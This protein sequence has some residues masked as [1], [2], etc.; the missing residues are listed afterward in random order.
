MLQHSDDLSRPIP[1][2]GLHDGCGTSTKT[3]CPGTD[4]IGSVQ[5]ATTPRF[6]NLFTAHVRSRLVGTLTHALRH[7]PEKYGIQLDEHGWANLAILLTNLHMLDVHWAW[8]TERDLVWLLQ[9][10]ADERFECRDGQIRALYG[11]SVKGVRAAVRRLPPP[12][13][14]HATDASIL[15]NVLTDGLE[16]M[17]RCYVHLTSDPAYASCVGASKNQDWVLLAVDTAP[18][19]RSGCEFY[20]AN[21]H[22]WQTTSIPPHLLQAL[23]QD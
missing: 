23:V 13:L 1:K 3:P 15:P 16:P 14:Y 4:H 5:P 20:Q 11:H 21:S 22:V 2:S 10:E 19:I 18:A 17:N 8:L 6:G 12:V 9:A 7:R